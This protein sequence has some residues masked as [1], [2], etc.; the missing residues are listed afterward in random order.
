V[1]RENTET[2][3]LGLEAFNRRDAAALQA[4]CTPDVELVPLRAALEDRAYRGPNAVAEMLRE[5]DESW[6]DLTYEIE[7][8]C[9]AGDQ[10][11]VFARLRGRGRATGIPVDQR[12]YLVMRFRDGLL[13]RFRTYTDQAEALSAVGLAE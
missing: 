5:F 13:A 6:E 8:L 9:E 1:S 3:Q 10:V 2:V 7:E 11:L 4:L 12:L